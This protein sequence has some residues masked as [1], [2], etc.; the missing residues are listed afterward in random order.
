M[1]FSDHNLLI[2]H[3]SLRKTFHIFVCFITTGP[4]STK[5]GTKNTW[6]KGIQI[7]SI[8]IP[9]QFPRGDNN[10]IAK[11]HQRLLKIFFSRTLGPISTK[12]GT[13]HLWVMG[14]QSFQVKVPVLFQGEIITKKQK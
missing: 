9:C 6:V 14:I 12:V 8:D 1:S 3:C 5:L 10:E 13:K 2:V 4:I 7:C 11:I